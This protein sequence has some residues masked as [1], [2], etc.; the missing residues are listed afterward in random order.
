MNIGIGGIIMKESEIEEIRELRRQGYSYNEIAKMTGRSKN[1][2]IKYCK[3][4]QVENGIMEYDSGKKIAIKQ[5]PL[6]SIKDLNELINA[7]V[8]TG[9]MTGSAIHSIHRGFTDDSMNDTERIT[10][11]MHGMAFLG[12]Q[13]YSTYRAL[14]EL[15]KNK[16]TNRRFK[17]V[18]SDDYNK[19]KERIKKLEEENKKLKEKVK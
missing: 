9:V 8:T 10:S 13:L 17:T 5:N 16:S 2:V 4:I 11:V 19:L 3:D 18:V 6:D 14:Q 1:T 12:G 15:N 7:S